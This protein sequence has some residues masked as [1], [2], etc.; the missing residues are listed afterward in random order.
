MEESVKFFLKTLT[1]GD[2]RLISVLEN[3]KLL[4]VDEFQDLD[5]A[6]FQFIKLFKKAV[7]SLRIV[8]I[9]DL[10]QNIYRFRGTSNEFL[11]TRLQKEIDPLLKTYTLTTNFRSTSRILDTINTVFR[12]EI[13]GG[14]ILPMKPSKITKLGNK[15]K[16]Y[17]YAVNPTPGVGEYE[18][19]TAETI[20]PIIQRAKSENKSVVLLFPAVK[21]A[22]FNI[23]TSLLRDYSRRLN[24]NLDLHQISKEDTTSITVP[25]TYNP[26][27]NVSP[28]Q[29]S[30]FHAAKGLEWDIVFVID[31]S[32]SMYDIRDNDEDTEGFIAEK[33]NLLYVGLTRSVQ[34][35]YIFANANKGGRHRLLASLGN[36]LSDVID[37]T[38]WGK[39]D[40]SPKSEHSLK[41]IAVTD[42]VRHLP[43]YPEIFDRVKKVSQNILTRQKTGEPMKYNNVYKEMI[44]RNREMAFGTFVDWKIKQQLCF[45]DTRCFQDILLDTLEFFSGIGRFLSKKEA[46]EDYETRVTKLK[47]DFLDSDINPTTPIEQFV[48]TSR[49]I[50]MHNGKYHSYIDTLK[51]LV[52]RIEYKIRLAAS[53]ADPSLKEQY[54][55]SQARDFFTKGN[56]GEIQCIYAPSSKYMGLPDGFENFVENNNVTNV[57]ID[58]L[59]SLNA[60]T[61]NLY[62]DIAVE[63][64]GDR[65]IIGEMDLYTDEQDG[66]M[67]EIKCSSIINP[68][69]LRDTGNCKNLLQ[70]LAYVA[71]AR[72]GTIK[73]NIRWAFLLNPLTSTYERYDLESWSQ[74]DSHEFML[75]LNDLCKL[76]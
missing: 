21:C 47:M 15:P 73:K 59:D 60:T 46:Y 71:M 5:D 61:D 3:F 11:R 55:I 12:D 7:P 20:L 28:V 50:A 52:K 1:E 63:Y 66:I 25:I 39:E 44:K 70:L 8:A 40:H 69:E 75:C 36:E 30:S 68:Q 38:Q 43:Q 48:N 64:S 14:H 45:G 56:M 32:D 65:I 35:L 42:L 10:A 74:E 17:E 4:V 31:V 34:E 13:K 54:I 57:I 33:T 18:Q 53:K 76:V 62:G 24:Y 37:L 9:G 16:Y 41:P 26:K 19:L 67:I 23:I 27:D 6:Q 58:T 22:S 29:F 51:Q 49:Y 72:H 2:R